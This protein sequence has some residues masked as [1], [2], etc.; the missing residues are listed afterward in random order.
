MMNFAGLSPKEL[1]GR[2][3]AL[4]AGASDLRAQMLTADAVD[5]RISY[6]VPTG[7][8]GLS[9]AELGKRLEELEKGAAQ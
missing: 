5:E 4:E 7:G 8:S 9:N 3:E 6:K 2:V 1:G